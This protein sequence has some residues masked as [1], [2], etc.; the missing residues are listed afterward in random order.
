MVKR[1]FDWVASCIGLVLL[2]PVF[3]IVGVLIKLESSGPVFYFQERVGKNK[4]LFKLFKFRTMHLHADQLTAITVGARDPRITRVG[5]FLR[6]YK[7]DELPQLIN[8]FKGEM[9][10]VGPRPEL[11]KFVKLYDQDQL[12]VIS[13]KPGITDYASIEFRNE[14]GMLEGKA[15]PVDFYIR[16]IMPVKLKLNLKYIGEQSFWVDLKIIFKT[17]FLILSR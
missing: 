4:K 14:N 12:R 9:S 2:L 11:E 8:V 5:L 3:I 17:I 16:E 7:I 13:V 1:L 6:K 10:L 15:D